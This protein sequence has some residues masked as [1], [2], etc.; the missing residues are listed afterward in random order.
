MVE[1]AGVTSFPAAL[2]SGILSFE[3][4]EF[5]YGLTSLPSFANQTSLSSVTIP[6][7]ITS[8]P[9]G[10]FSGCS[11]L[12][13]VY[14]KPTTPPTLG[15]SVFDGTPDNMMILV[16]DESLSDYQNASGWN[17]Y[18]DHIRTSSSVS[19]SGIRINTEGGPMGSESVNVNIQ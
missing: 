19:G 16:P 13:E 10:T 1:I 14:M 7:Q 4:L 11:E 3:E 18:Y 17:A 8:I 5:F 2:P 6:R 12:V 9:N 15:S